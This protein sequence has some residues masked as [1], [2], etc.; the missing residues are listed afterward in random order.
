[1]K[2]SAEF[3]FFIVYEQ[4]ISKDI[5][6]LAHEIS[7]YNLKKQYFAVQ[8]K[9]PYFFQ[10]KTKSS[11]KWVKYRKKVFPQALLAHKVAEKWDRLHCRFWNW[12]PRFIEFEKNLLFSQIILNNFNIVG[13]SNFT[14]ILGMP[15][16]PFL[17]CQVSYER[18]SS[19]AKYKVKGFRLGCAGLFRFEAKKAKK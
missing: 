3:R 7:L 12:K 10:C 4:F 1:M 5:F 17:E 11:T 16:K 18:F 19:Q 6:S 13:N 2:L 15:W 9:V 14:C 8:D